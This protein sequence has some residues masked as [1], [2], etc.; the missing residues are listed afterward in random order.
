VLVIGVN[1]DESVRRLKGP[2]RPVNSTLERCRVL[3][4]LS[5]VDFVT[6]FG[7]NNPIPLIHHVRPDVYVKGGDYTRETLPEAEVVESYGGALQI[8]PYIAN[9]STTGVIERI[10][11][12]NTAEQ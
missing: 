1:T 4:G 7:E 10:R 2:T 12:L 11:K 9:H 3:A 5:C 6:P 8:V